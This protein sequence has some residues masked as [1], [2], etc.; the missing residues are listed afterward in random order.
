M[1][2]WKFGIVGCGLIGTIHAKAIGAIPTAQLVSVCDSDS[3]KA[4]SLAG[5]YRCKSFTDVRQMCEKGDVDIITIAT[6]SGLHMEPA[7]IAAECGKHVLCEKPLDI[8]LERIDAMISAHQKSGTK[9]GGIFQSR[10]SEPVGLLKTAIEQGRFGVVTYAGAYVPWWREDKYY[11]NTWRG[12]WKLDGGGA[13]M[14]QSIH[15]VDLLCY[16]MPPVESIKSFAATLGHK[17]IE[18]EDT[19]VAVMKFKTG[20]LGVLYGTTAAYPGQFRR[21]EISGTKGSVVLTNES[22]T[23]WQL[24]QEMPEDREIREKFS[25]HKQSGGAANPGD[26]GFE[27]HKKNILAFLQSL[28]GSSDFE[29]SGTEARKSVELILKLYADAGRMA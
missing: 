23:V 17:Q 13:I 10:F 14:N 19:A 27:N 26:I 25:G 3:S 7:V 24:E 1:K 29:L 11:N 18:T 21:F 20:S 28:E 16:L 4:E 8:N 15:L 6:P 9:L 12:T 5:Q 22:F 2:T